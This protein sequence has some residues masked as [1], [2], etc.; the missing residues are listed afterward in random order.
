MICILPVTKLKAGLFVGFLM[1]TVKTD[2]CIYMLLLGR[3]F[4]YAS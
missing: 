1:V 2:L 4:R 3:I